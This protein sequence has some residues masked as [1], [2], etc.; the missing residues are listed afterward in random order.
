[1][2]A[3]YSTIFLLMF[4]LDYMWLSSTQK[5]YDRMVMNVQGTSL[6]VNIPAALL[7]YTILFLGIVMISI[8]YTRM[9]MKEYGYVHSGW[10]FLFGALMGFFVYSVFNL[11]NLAI[12][13]KY[14]W[15]VGLMDTLWGSF[16]FGVI[17]FV[18]VV[19][20]TK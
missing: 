12:F 16:L 4:L 9:I 19:G 7:C 20:F 5:I 18:G 17:T 14:S 2:W 6:D 15:Q 3:V 13:K 10:A 11:T 1:M 8:P